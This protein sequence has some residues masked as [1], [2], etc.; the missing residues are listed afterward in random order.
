MND[1]KRTA[2]ASA[3]LV[4]PKQL[5]GEREAKIRRQ[6]TEMLLDAHAETGV[7]SLDVSVGEQRIATATL[8][9]PKTV[10][11]T[12]TAEAQ[13]I[14]WVRQHAPEMVIEYQPPPVVSVAP[15]FTRDLL[16]RL[17]YRDGEAF[18]PTTGEQVPGIR[19]PY[20]PGPSSYRVGF[21]DD[22]KARVLE[23]WR[24][25]ELAELDEV[26]MLEGGQDA[27]E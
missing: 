25:G 6:L 27:D 10:Q 22:G 17:V 18:D 21:V 9:A 20:T 16:A 1:L 4:A 2:L 11:A 12:I 5:V 7:K 8:V 15:E 24:A 23:A 3:A 26:P 19:G 14:E 13:Y